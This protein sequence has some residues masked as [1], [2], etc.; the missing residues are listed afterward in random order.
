MSEHSATPPA[1]HERDEL[2]S[3]AQAAKIVPGRPSANCVWR[4]CRR[5][6]MSRAGERIYLQHVRV[7]GKVY[8]RAEWL[9]HFGRALA[10]ADAA[11]FRQ[12]DSEACPIPGTCRRRERFE[13]HRRASV[14]QAHQELEDAGL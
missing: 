13:E 10:E 2:L 14:A 1:M 4:W 12:S 9:Q 3:L 11:Y 7:G 5:G 6:V 8:T